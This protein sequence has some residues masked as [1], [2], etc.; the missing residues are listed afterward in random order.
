[1]PATEL[2]IVEL[3]DRLAWEDWLEQNHKT[4][5]GVWLKIAKKSAPVTT[6]GYPEALEEAL[7]F[8]WIDGQKARHDEHYWLQRFTPRGPRS[9]WSQINRAKATELIEQQRMR[10]AGLEQVQAA[11]RDGRW[12]DAYES[13]RNATVPDDLQRALASNPRA[14]EF[15]AT[16]TGASRYAFLYRLHQVKKPEARAKRISTYVEML[17]QG[18]T[19]H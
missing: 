7:R 1:M 13:Q 5:D 19:F 11:Q 12:E 17:E 2:P 3:S 4:S 16:L 15:F 9:R 8:G 14:A 18:R 6:V 10:P